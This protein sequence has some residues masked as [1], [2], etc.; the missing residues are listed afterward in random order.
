MYHVV[1]ALRFAC[2]LLAVCLAVCCL[3]A[4]VRRL[5]RM[6]WSICILF[7]SEGLQF[8]RRPQLFL[9]HVFIAA[10]T[11][12]LF[13]GIYYDLQPDTSGVWNRLMGL[14]AQGMLVVF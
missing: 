6:L 3:L 1:V 12:V 9:V 10:A 8:V 4:V 13:G 11:G 5:K 7:H 2:C 14:F